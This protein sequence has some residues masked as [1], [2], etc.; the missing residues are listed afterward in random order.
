MTT[1][2]SPTLQSLADHPRWV[3]W[4]A[5]SKPDGT[6]TKMP[7]R[8]NGQRASSS[9]P[10]NWG[11]RADAEMWS[12]ALPK[13]CDTGGVGIMFG[14]LDH[15]HSLGG[16]DLDTCRD[17]ETGVLQPWAEEIVQRFET[18]WEVSPS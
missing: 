17:P 7:Y 5:E 1:A 9:N 12:A 10:T 11:V 15:E 4:R 16:L 8:A 3:A 6:Q 14:E 13:P 2:S 18:Y